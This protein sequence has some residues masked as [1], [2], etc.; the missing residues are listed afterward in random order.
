MAKTIKDLQAMAKMIEDLQAMAKMTKDL[1]AMAKVKPRTTSKPWLNTL[2]LK[3]HI[4]GEGEGGR[5]FNIVFKK[6][7]KPSCEPKSGYKDIVRQKDMK[8]NMVT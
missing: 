8:Q 3:G 1:Q 4:R 7:I 6:E 5:S 2:M